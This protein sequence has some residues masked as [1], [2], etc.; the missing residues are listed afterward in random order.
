M[1][2]SI[3]KIISTHH[4]HSGI[5]AEEQSIG[6]YEFEQTKSPEEDLALLLKELETVAARSNVY[7]VSI[8]PSGNIEDLQL[9][10]KYMVEID[11]KGSME[12]MMHFIY[13]IGSMRK[14]MK[15]ERFEIAPTSKGAS[16]MTCTMSVSKLNFKAGLS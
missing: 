12:S 10:T 14:L 2:C 6:D 13:S 11:C 15:I 1:C 7:I 9:Y 16:E 3:F 4:L 5:L 8:N